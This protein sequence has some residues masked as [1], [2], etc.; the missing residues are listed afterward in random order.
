MMN[1]KLSSIAV[2]AL[3]LSQV[4]YATE[5]SAPVK[6]A[7]DLQSMS[8]Q[9]WW[10]DRLDLAPLRQHAAESSPMDSKYNYANEFKKLDLKA[11]KKDI[12]TLM[13]SSQEWWPA[14][15]GHYGPF[16]IRMAWH[17]AGTYRVED[18]RGGA[19]GGQQRFEPLNSWPDNANLDKARRLLWP[20]KSKYGNKISWADLMVL[21][22]NVALESMG[23]KTFGFAGGRTDDW[24]A[25]LVYWGPEKKFLADERYKEG[26]KLQKPLAAVQMGLIYVNP[27]GPNGN[28]DPQAAANDIRETFGRMA[29]NDEETVALIAGG[30]TFGK[31]HGQGDP[32]KC[33]GAEPAAAGIEEQGLGWKNKCGKGNAGDT[34]TSGLEGAWTGSPTQWTIQYLSNLFAFDWVKT[35]SPAGATQW[36]PSDANAASLVPDAHDKDKRHAPIMLTTD[37]AL[38]TDPSYQKIAKR[39]LDNPKEFELAFAKAWFK[40]TH[41]DL[42]PRTR[43]LGAEVPSEVLIWQDPIPAVN[44]KLINASDTES[45]KNKILK[46]GLTVP[47]LVRTAWASAA[48]FRGTDMRGGANGARVRLAPEK[49]WQVNNPDELAKTLAQLDAIQKDFNQ[50]QLGGKK[51]SLADL[52]VLGGSAAVEQAAK[53]AGYS[54]KVPFTPGRMDASQEQTDVSAF[55]VLEPKADAFRNYYGEGN[56]LSPTAM[57]IDRANMLTLT[58]PEMTVLVGGLRVLNT[59]TG[60]SKQGVLTSKP[61]TL[62]NDFFINLLDM[63]TQWEKS[64]KSEG[65][66]EGKDRKT[67][68]LKWTATPV[69]LIFGSHSELR[70]IAE[71]YASADGKQKFVTDFVNAWNKV[72]TLDRFDLK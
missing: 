50:T 20:I 30:H 71:V 34:I 18:G 61:G 69:D 29:M 35:K 70:A 17:S 27:E 49:D 66:Y 41:R 33:I 42:G 19:G 59:N 10:P 36:I 14:D 37:L 52:I 12:E 45:L 46:S 26:R 54:I 62:S 60:Q 16:F 65:V 11:V 8:N 13:T 44:H 53:V 57:L 72:M 32:S 6:T 5:S 38:K 56:L 67:G 40:L 48:S 58:V 47:E 64:S 22:G 7:T 51:V 23:F 63:S 21:T 39:F 9:F 68:E 28:P 4:G 24:E 3:S 55:A 43:Y 1:T 31:T 2:L 15:Y 25:D